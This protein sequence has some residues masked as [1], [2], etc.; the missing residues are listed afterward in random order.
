MYETAVSIYIIVLAIMF[1]TGILNDISSKSSI[2]NKV[3]YNYE[4]GDRVIIRDYDKTLNKNIY[5]GAVILDRRY[6]TDKK[7]KNMPY[8]RMKIYDKQIEIQVM[9]ERRIWATEIEY[10]SFPDYSVTK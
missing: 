4:V 3:N 6:G 2:N 7:N 10:G 8:Y 1:A 9:D 5:K